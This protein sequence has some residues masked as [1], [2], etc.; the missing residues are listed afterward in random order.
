[1]EDP[2]NKESTGSQWSGRRVD[3]EGLD[4]QVTK[5]PEIETKVRGENA[6]DCEQGQ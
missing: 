3:N 2:L 5:L 4:E 6:K 1:M